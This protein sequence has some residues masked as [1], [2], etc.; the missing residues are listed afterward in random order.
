M[1]PPISQTQ[2]KAQGRHRWKDEAQGCIW[3]GAPSTVGHPLP[4]VTP[5]PTSTC[6][7]PELGSSPPPPPPGSLPTFE[8]SKPQFLA[9]PSS[10]FGEQVT[11]ILG[12]RLWFNVR[13]GSLG[14]ARAELARRPASL[15]STE[16]KGFPHLIAF[17]LCFLVLIFLP[18]YQ[19]PK[20]CHD[21]V[22]RITLTGNGILEGTEVWRGCHSS[23]PFLSVMSQACG[24]GR[25]REGRAPQALPAHKAWCWLCGLWPPRPSALRQLWRG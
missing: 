22:L 19:N 9:K 2:A 25:G 18:S 13:R 1:L 10:G 5:V 6:A 3:R 7:R 21:D 23:A 8:H 20:N 24:D 4:R 14:R 16:K 17:S 11:H 15:V 12:S